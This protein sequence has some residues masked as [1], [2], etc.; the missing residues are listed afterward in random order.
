MR[1]I[2]GVVALTTV[3]AI[4]TAVPV[5]A[6]IATSVAGTAVCDTATGQ[7]V[8]TWTFTNTQTVDS[9]I[10]AAPITTPGLTAGS[11]VESSASFSPLAVTAQGG[12]STAVTHAT[13]NA[14][15]TITVTVH[16]TSTQLPAG[17]T[18]SGVATLTGGCVATTTTTATA[19][20][21]ASGQ[22]P[23]VGQNTGRLPWIA[24]GLVGTGLALVS[25]RRRPRRA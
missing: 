11:S 7:Q 1:K 12:T 17:F 23:H 10:D 25:V 13:G 14:V 24:L 19:V 15:G 6:G 9:T 3:F 20:D 5:S 8:I 18:T 16:A 4:G 22:L 21:P 2:L